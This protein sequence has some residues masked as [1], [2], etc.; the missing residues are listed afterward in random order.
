MFC[1]NPFQNFVASITRVVALRVPSV[2]TTTPGA[3]PP[4][5]RIV[6]LVLMATMA[7]PSLASAREHAESEGVAHP[8]TPAAAPVAQSGISLNGCPSLNGVAG[9]GGCVRVWVTA[10]LAISTT[11]PLSLT[12][13]L[14]ER[15][16][17]C[18]S[19]DCMWTYEDSN[20]NLRLVRDAW[21]D[22]GS[23]PADG[24]LM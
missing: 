12:I 8:P 11:G 3:P 14:I 2:T 23:G 18:V 1:F 13:T 7:V 21:L 22:C 16:I 17:E 24:D 19:C 10:D 5:R 6:A 4:F 15:R 20:G 9:A